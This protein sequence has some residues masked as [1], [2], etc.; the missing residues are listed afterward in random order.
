MPSSHANSLCFFVGYLTMAAADG[1]GSY[2]AAAVCAAS[3]LY[4]FLVCYYR[5]YVSMDHTVPQILAGVVHGTAVG[6]AS[7]ALVLPWYSGH[8]VGLWSMLFG[9]R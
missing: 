2:T 5:V 8:K 7:H 6:V 1:Y 4:T 3:V 9:W